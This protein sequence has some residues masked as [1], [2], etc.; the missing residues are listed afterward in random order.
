MLAYGFASRRFI[1]ESYSN[2]LIESTYKLGFVIRNA[3][4]QLYNRATC[5]AQAK[6]F[7]YAVVI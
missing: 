4:H 7:A 5:T 3:T 1:L 2:L 6:A